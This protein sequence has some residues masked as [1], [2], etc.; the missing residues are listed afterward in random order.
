MTDSL[1]HLLAISSV[2]TMLICSWR[3]IVPAE[4]R[5]HLTFAGMFSGFKRECQ[6]LCFF[7]LGICVM[8]GGSKSSQNTHHT[9][10]QYAGG[11]SQ[12]SS[13]TTSQTS[14]GQIP[15]VDSPFPVPDAYPA[16][17][18]EWEDD[19]CTADDGIPDSWRRRTH[20]EHYAADD[21][22]VIG[23][24]SI[25]EA[26]WA[27]CDPLL[28][29]T[30]NWPISDLDLILAGHDPLADFD[31]TPTSELGKTDWQDAC[32]LWY[33]TDANGNGFIDAYE[34][35][36]F[37]SASE[38]NYDVLV[39]VKT[40]RS[41]ALDWDGVRGFHKGIVVPSTGASFKL[42][43]PRGTNTVLNLIPYPG[44]LEGEPV[45]EELEGQFWIADMTVDFIDRATGDTTNS[46]FYSFPTEPDEVDVIHKENI[47]KFVAVCLTSPNSSKSSSKF[48]SI[49][50]VSAHGGR[51]GFFENPV[52]ELNGKSYKIKEHDHLWHQGRDEFVGPFTLTN[53]VGV[54]SAQILWY[55]QEGTMNPMFDYTANLITY[56][57][58]DENGRIK[59]N[60]K[61]TDGTDEATA[62]TYV[63][64]CIKPPFSVMWS[65]N[66]FSPHL[67]E[68]CYIHVR[69]P[70]CVHDGQVMWVEAEVMRLTTSG[71]QHVGWIDVSTAQPGHQKRIGMINNSL[72][73]EWD[74]I[75]T[76]SAALAD[77][78]DIF[79]HGTEP[80]HRAL[81][82][83]ISG[84]PLPPP[85][86]TVFVR[87]READ[88]D[89]AP[90]VPGCEADKT[91]HVPQ[92]LKV[93]MSQA[94]YLNFCKPVIYPFSDWPKVVA[95]PNNIHNP[96]FPYDPVMYSGAIGMSKTEV[97]DMIFGYV[98]DLIPDNVN[99]RVTKKNPK[100]RFKTIKYVLQSE[101]PKPVEALGHT[102]DFS[103]RNENPAGT[104]YVYVEKLRMSPCYE[105]LYA[106]NRDIKF[107]YSLFT[108]PFDHTNLAKACATC[109]T[110]EFIHTL[111]LVDKRMYGWDNHNDKSFGYDES[112]IMNVYQKSN[113]M[114]GMYFYK[115]KSYRPIN[116]LYLEF[117]L[118][119]P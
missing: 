116:I 45:P 93:E 52:V 114:Y 16:H 38:M 59:V 14:S 92:V 77:S 43:L 81:P 2:L 33:L 49:G 75:A 67:G 107:R 106:L 101:D 112:W 29:S 113:H 102:R 61:L 4:I 44:F 7:I 18:G 79:T 28:L 42:R 82:Q 118:P 20:T 110:H 5:K 86:Y 32:Y 89:T 72:T 73:I 103:W 80:F 1:T 13:Q 27:N 30:R 111:G 17:W 26:F 94:A 15:R 117:I 97:E 76:E 98:G 83:V 37:D 84:E 48:P 74:G 35:F 65:T 66:N 85:Y 25:L 56:K 109:G 8:Y 11:Q 100:G 70:K 115:W 68:K 60:A 55:A 119:K 50:G 71:W 34:E 22:P 104:A 99:V 47:R 90:I 39:S 40:T 64:P 12:T 88:S 46:V 6:I 9:G 69:L 19:T 105:E 51:G 53:I 36:G 54:A 62:Y 41:A 78:P 23:G 57:A 3:I 21:T 31:P 24:L 58:Y 87:V 95:D 108:I 96:I 91:I 10:G 63:W